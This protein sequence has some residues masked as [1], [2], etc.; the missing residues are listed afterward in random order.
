[1]RIGVV[2]PARA[3]KEEVAARVLAFAA[4][5]FP[6]VD[7][8]IDPQCFAEAGH[9]AGPDELRAE[10][11]L[12]Y[13]NDP[14][15]DAIWFA[16]GGYGSNRILDEIMPALKPAAYRKRYIGYSDMGFM[17]GAMYARR[18]GRVAHGPM[19]IDM[20][21]GGGDKTVTRSLDWLTGGTRGLEP[22]LGDRP[23]AAFNLSILTAMIGTPWLPDLTDHVLLI[24]EVGEPHYRMDRMLWQLSQST[25][26]KG[27][28][29]L[30][31]GGVTDIVENDVAFGEEVEPMF[32]KWARVMGV[33]YLG[34]AQVGHMRDNWVVPFGMRG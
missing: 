32:E 13:A 18:V 20:G 5:V 24:E 1:M 28:A 23:A 29:G 17:L 11:F 16:R 31:L 7:L 33:P 27:I 14:A 8:V 34:R 3:I 19:L 4:I 22:G 15:F 10:T 12:R 21:T 9:F 30:R 26:L 2:A 6:S 25:Q